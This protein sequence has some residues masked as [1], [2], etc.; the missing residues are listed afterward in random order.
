MTAQK[1]FDAIFRLLD[2]AVRNKFPF[3]SY[4]KPKS[5][6]LHLWVQKD[7]KK[8]TVQKFDVS[9]FVMTPF[10]MQ[11]DDGIIFPVEKSTRYVADFNYKNRH[12][13]ALHSVQTAVQAGKPVRM[14][15]VELVS[16]TVDF[17]RKGGA[18][19]VVTSRK[20]SFLKTVSDKTALFKN[21]LHR[22]PEAFVYIWCHPEVGFWLG[23]TPETLLQVNGNRFETMALAGT[24]VAGN[25]S[26]VTWGD[27]EIE[28]Q[29]YV[30]RYILDRLKN[31]DVQTSETYTKKAGNLLH[32]CTDITGKSAEKSIDKLI[33]ELHP[34]PAVC[35]LPLEEAKSFILK[36]EGYKREFY[37]GFLGE[38]NVQTDQKMSSD[39]YVNLR[40]MKI[41][42]GNPEEIDVFVGGG[43]TAGSDPEKEWLETEV[44]SQ[45]MLSVLND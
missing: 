13:A 27:K 8:Y 18:E 15:Y 23:A 24:Q 7:T 29:K 33:N 14:Q 5:N 6:E 39:L 17:I 37:T 25:S 28:E 16:K 11:S 41:S 31:R 38:L 44:K 20:I 19:K 43:I 1:S 4:C 42:D 36:N 12:P 45:T 30:T 3:V 22:F 40:C 35:G 26:E 10:E 2:D 32:I 21:L 9:G 34:T